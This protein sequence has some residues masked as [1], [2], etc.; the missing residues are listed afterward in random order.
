MKDLIKQA[1][2]GVLNRYITKS[3]FYE[4][5]VE[6]YGD[7][8]R[9]LDYLV[10]R[11]CLMIPKVDKTKTKKQQRAYL[12]AVL[13]S[14]F[15]KDVLR[16]NS[17]GLKTNRRGGGY[18]QTRN[19]ETVG[20]AEIADNRQPIDEVIERERLKA[21]NDAIEQLP[22]QYRETMQTFI[23]NDFN[24]KKSAAA[25]GISAAAFYMRLRRARAYLN[26]NNIL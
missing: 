17:R 15:K 20:F 21:L 1:A 9:A 22:R 2:A 26:E 3:P 12:S 4:M 10:W 7:Y 5:I 16:W 14:E 11:G 13:T 19:E 18:R 23:N 6:V 24:K 25:L 8:T